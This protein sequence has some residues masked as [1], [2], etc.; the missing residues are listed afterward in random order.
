MQD[1]VI[2]CSNR[3]RKGLEEIRI[4]L[5]PPLDER[6]KIIM[7][8]EYS[9]GENRGIIASFIVDGDSLQNISKSEEEL[10]DN[11]INQI[12]EVLKIHSYK[13]NQISNLSFDDNLIFWIAETFNEEVQ[14]WKEHLRCMQ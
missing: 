1:D 10:M 11:L 2:V 8:E 12:S 7:I 3:F 6:Q 9:S 14:A 5:I 4:S 13:L